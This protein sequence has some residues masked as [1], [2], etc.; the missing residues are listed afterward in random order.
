MRAAR[1]REW[2]VALAFRSATSMF[3]WE[4]HS[5]GTTLKPHMTAL[6][7]LVPW[8]L[9]GIRHTL[10]RPS[11]RDSWYART[12]SSPAYSPWEPAKGGSLENSGHETGNI[13]FAALSF[14]V[15]EPSEIIDWQSVRS[16]A[17]S[18]LM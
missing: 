7:G 16:L 2:T 18:R 13:S 11:P 6:A 17:S 1:S 3:P 15:H 8:A 5:T 9:V 4:S 12:T 10:R 14:M